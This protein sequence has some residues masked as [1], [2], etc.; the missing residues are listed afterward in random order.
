MRCWRWKKDFLVGGR[1]VVLSRNQLKKY[2]LDSCVIECCCH[3]LD[4]QKKRLWKRKKIYLFVLI[5]FLC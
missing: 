2:R 3:D 1:K 4:I 5:L